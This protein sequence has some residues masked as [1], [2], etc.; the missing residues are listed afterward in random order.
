MGF[1]QNHC[2]LCSKSYDLSY[3]RDISSYPKELEYL[4]AIG[5][6]HVASKYIDRQCL[7][8]LNAD[9]TVD[10]LLS[11]VAFAL[12]KCKKP[13]SIRSLID[14]EGSSRSISVDEH[15]ESDVHPPPTKRSRVAEDIVATPLKPGHAVEIAVTPVASAHLDAPPTQ[16]RPAGSSAHDARDVQ[17][18]MPAT[19]ALPNRGRKPTNPFYHIYHMPGYAV[20]EKLAAEMARFRQISPT[21]FESASSFLQRPTVSTILWNFDFEMLFRVM[22]WCLPYTFRFHFNRMDAAVR[23]AVNRK[24][25][26][27]QVVIRRVLIAALSIRSIGSQ[28][29]LSVWRLLLGLVHFAS[30]AKA[31]GGK[32]AHALG[33]SSCLSNVRLLISK[34]K[35]EP[36]SYPFIRE[37]QSK[38][39]AAVACTDNSQVRMTVKHVRTDHGD[40][41]LHNSMFG[42]FAVPCDSTL[43][44][45]NSDGVPATT[46]IWAKM[47]KEKFSPLF[48]GNRVLRTPEY[49]RELRFEL[50]RVLLHHPR[51]P[52]SLKHRMGSYLSSVRQR[53][54]EQVEERHPT[55]YEPVAF[56]IFAT[57]P[58]WATTK[59]GMADNL[60]YLAA[61]FKK[62]L[63]NPQNEGSGSLFF[64]EVLLK[65]AGIQ[66]N[67]SATDDSRERADI[68]A[69]L[70]PPMPAGSVHFLSC[71]FATLSLT[72]SVIAGIRKLKF[73]CLPEDAVEDH[74]V[75]RLQGRN[76]FASELKVR[77]NA[78]LLAKAKT[79]IAEQQPTEK[80]TASNASRLLPQEWTKTVPAPQP[81][82]LGTSSADSSSDDESDAS[83]DDDLVDDFDVSNDDA[84]EDG[85]AH[86]DP[87]GNVV[88]DEGMIRKHAEQG[89]KS[90]KTVVDG[91]KSAFSSLHVQSKP[92]IPTQNRDNAQTEVLN[93][94]PP[95]AS[96]PQGSSKQRTAW[97]AAQR[98]LVMEY[99]GSM[100]VLFPGLHALFIHLSALQR[101][102]PFVFSYVYYVVLQRTFDIN[103]P[104]D[105]FF[106]KNEAFCALF[107]G[108]FQAAIDEYD[109][110][111]DTVINELLNSRGD[112]QFSTAIHRVVDDIVHKLCDKRS[113]FGSGSVA[114]QVLD[115]LLEQGP[116]YRMSVRA[117]REGDYLV[118]CALDANVAALLLAT[119]HTNYVYFYFFWLMQLCVA[120]PVERRFLQR[121]RSMT[122][123]VR[124]KG[125]NEAPDEIYERGMS[126]GARYV[127]EHH[128]ADADPSSAAQI[129]FVLGKFVAS[130]LSAIGVNRQ[131]SSFRSVPTLEQDRSKVRTSSVLRHLLSG[132]PLDD[133]FEI[134]V[135]DELQ[136]RNPKLTDDRRRAVYVKFLEMADRADKYRDSLSKWKEGFH[137]ICT[138]VD[139]PDA[140]WKKGA[141]KWFRFLRATHQECCDF[142]YPETSYWGTH[143]S[144][145]LAVSTFTDI[146]TDAIGRKLRRSFSN[147]DPAVKRL[148][149]ELF[150]EALYFFVEERDDWYFLRSGRFW[151]T[152]LEKCL[153]DYRK[154][155]GFNTLSSVAEVKQHL[156]GALVHFGTE[157]VQSFFVGK[158]TVSWFGK[159]PDRCERRFNDTLSSLI[160]DEIGCF[161][162]DRVPETFATSDVLALRR[163]VR[164]P[165]K[166]SKC[167]AQFQPVR[168]PYNG[169]SHSQDLNEY[170]RSVM[171]RH[172]AFDGVRQPQRTSSSSQV[173][174]AT[175]S[176]SSAGSTASS[177]SF[178]SSST[179]SQVTVHS[180]ATSS[181]PLVADGSA[182]FSS[183]AFLEDDDV[184]ID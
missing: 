166:K 88:V 134:K 122:T 78:L 157:I 54:H 170:V 23:T 137:A 71:D 24:S 171:H 77:K 182:D 63:W 53:V 184:E 35:R 85:A 56:R 126:E 91:L 67:V 131:T 179:S 72:R 116:V 42:A 46:E 161:H 80:S 146:C 34:I 47:M 14:S 164:K 104:Q 119:G 57:Q 160:A 3:L 32:L 30:S 74:S 118:D 120:P 82:L 84:T 165:Q 50:V 153:K 177:S 90:A 92:N 60:L 58:T 44:T 51:T 61:R 12:S 89:G 4:G 68:F 83:D 6:T 1:G 151:R 98:E 144:A 123:H 17:S 99:V 81:A 7:A 117:V 20:C 76:T 38:Q 36:A 168:R 106:Q 159:P 141:Q 167:E 73:H 55:I 26:D 33:L 175:P 133:D 64:N 115:F 162:K 135:I 136:D 103:K 96:A 13:L 39:H 125:H 140:A 15:N 111:P 75:E 150:L 102:M 28:Q 11:N 87:S 66:R 169:D 127:S 156:N 5:I 143:Y 163:A 93:A 105:K 152:E 52:E 65:E 107:E 10:T 183:V 49:T 37:V 25:K 148:V 22:Q 154:N 45:E 110:Y 109:M 41:T 142:V 40:K 158:K 86:I 173:S 138:V 21:L 128:P 178:A 121:S 9:Q 31:A 8:K 16:H 59:P 145:V 100:R 18:A 101:Y 132:K 48:D 149:A 27:L 29:E 70:D 155:T 113:S 19:A 174:S 62:D 108:L 112:G 114:A 79:P 172:H 181:L 2:F 130:F 124:A 95:T 94:V 147:L 139:A 43:Y 176:S 97:T 69:S 129:S 180:S